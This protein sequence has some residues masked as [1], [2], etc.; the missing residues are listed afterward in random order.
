MNI[1]FKFRLNIQ[2]YYLYFFQGLNSKWEKSVK[3]VIFLSILQQTFFSILSDAVWKVRNSYFWTLLLMTW[4]GNTET[5]FLG[6]VLSHSTIAM[7]MILNFLLCESSQRPAQV[8]SNHCMYNC[9]SLRMYS[10]EESNFHLEYPG[11]L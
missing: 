9:L 4:K 7:S 11:Y 2:F 5:W 10:Y 6:L 3:R 1:L 8:I